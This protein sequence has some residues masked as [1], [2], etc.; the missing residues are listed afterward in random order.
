MTPEQF[1]ALASLTRWPADGP[2]IHAMRL[3][4]VDGHTQ[5]EA[6]RI[7]GALPAAISRAM[8]RARQVRES[9]QVLAALIPGAAAAE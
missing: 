1:S 4:L 6:A 9:A 7:T 2:V 3:V 5:A 8:R